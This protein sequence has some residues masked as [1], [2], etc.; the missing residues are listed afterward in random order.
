MIDTTNYP[1][2]V[3]EAIKHLEREFRHYVQFYA[4]EFCAAFDDTRH[5]TSGKIQAYADALLS[6]GYT[7]ENLQA[8]T[9]EIKINLISQLK[10]TK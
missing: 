8:I 7:E 4:G 9:S 6:L 3:Q 10:P 2:K 1:P 5:R